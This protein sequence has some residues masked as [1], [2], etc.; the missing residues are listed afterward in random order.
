MRSRDLNWYTTILFLVGIGMSLFAL[1]QSLGKTDWV[2]WVVTVYI[3]VFELFPLKL[4]SGDQYCPG[5]VGYVY[6]MYQYGFYSVPFPLILS[7]FLFYLQRHRSIET[8]NW[9]R[10]FST[11]GMYFISSLVMYLVILSTKHLHAVVL[12]FLAISAYELA[13]LLLLEGIRKTV[14][15]SRF[16]ENYANKLKE[17]IIPAFVCVIILPPFLTDEGTD[18]LNHLLTYTLLTGLIYFF[19]NKYLEQIAIRKHVAS[20]ILS[21]LE[22][23]LSPVMSGHGKRVGLLTDY[24]CDV[25]QYPKR[26]KNALVHVAIAHDIGKM[27]LPTHLFRKRGSLTLSEER[28]YQSHVEKGAQVVYDFFANQRYADWVLHHHERWD[29]TG[30]PKGLRGQ[31]IPLESRILALANRLD[32]LLIRHADYKTVFHLLQ[33]MSE[34]ELDPNLIS[35]LKE[36]D[37]DKMRMICDFQAIDNQVVTLTMEREDIDEI[38]GLVGESGMIVYR[39]G[40]LQ[41]AIPSWVSAEEIVRLAERSL[42]DQTSFSET[43]L[44]STGCIEMHFYPLGSDVMIFKNDLTYVTQYQQQLRREIMASYR[45]VIDMLSQHKIVLT[46]DEEELQKHLG[47]YLESMQ[48]ATAQDVSNSRKLVEKYFGKAQ[49]MVKIMLA[50]SEGTTNIIKHATGGEITLFEKKDAFQVLISDTGNGIPLHELPKTIL[51]SGYSSKRSLGKGFTVM[52]KSA[53][54]VFIHTSS[55]GTQVLL[56]FK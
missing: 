51:V 25:V 52:C 6:L 20:C 2:Y 47:S 45:E 4:Q 31:E 19:S 34:T 49:S 5:S 32:H 11:V 23:R 39:E 16:L 21:L 55:Q 29:G 33:E 54:K 15:G 10:F 28:E 43:F 3:I 44:I 30:Y 26:H 1:P 35:R 48:V 14:E 18:L 7:T 24:L 42:R 53:D 17:L 8:L 9:Y 37:L 13:N 46:L 56:E 41:G 38:R 22:T 12:C 27:G 50:V 40:A 36:S